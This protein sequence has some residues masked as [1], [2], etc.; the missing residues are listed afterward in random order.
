M[1]DAL[2]IDT[3]TGNPYTELPVADATVRT[4]IDIAIS[5][6]RDA[7]VAALGN[8]E[9]RNDSGNPIPVNGTVSVGNF[10]SSQTVTGPLTDAQL[11]ATPVPVSG[12]VTVSDGSGPLTVDG[13]VSVGNFPATQPVSGTV[14]VSSIPDVEIKNDVGNAIPTAVQNFPATQAVS[15]TVAVSNFPASTEIANDVGNPVPVSGTVTATP[16]GTQDVDGNVAHGATDAGNPVKVGGKYFQATPTPVTNGQRVDAW[17]DAF[18]R[19]MVALHSAELNTST[20]ITSLR[21]MQIAQRYTILADSV[22]DG[23]AGF[24]TLSTTGSGVAPAVSGGEGVL[25]SG[26]AASSSSQMTSTTVRYFPGQSAWLNSAVRFGDTGVVGNT[27]RVGVFTVSGTA[28]QDGFYFEL[29]DTTLNAV[30]I[31][32]GVIQSSVP[33]TSWSRFAQSPFTLDTNYHQFEIRFTSNGCQFY[34]DNVVR[35]VFAGTTAAV[36]NTLNFPMTLQTVNTTATANCVIAVRNIGMG[37]FGQQPQDYSSGQILADQAGTGAVL[38]FN[39]TTPVDFMWVTDT[40]TTTTNI[41]RVDPFGGTPAASLGIPVF[42]QTPTPISVVPPA[43]SVKVYAPAG[44]NIAV[45]GLRY[46]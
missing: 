10:P 26:A 19:Q 6:L 39:F 11:R 1:V 42:N 3:T 15:G 30:V 9:I 24:W 13:T 32:N 31:K 35:H 22:A 12:A 38:T 16:T 34:V 37:R 28:P 18:G 43:S 27:R 45:Y 2:F 4:R 5:A 40:G 7:I 44:A 33:T 8:V 14:A 25:Q 23:L 36:T 29:A 17:F 20:Q 41:S 46:V 21:D